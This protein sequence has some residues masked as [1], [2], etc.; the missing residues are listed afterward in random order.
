[1]PQEYDVIIVGAGTAGLTA[2]LYA[3]RHGLN[4]AIIEEF[5]TGN[6]VSNVDNIETFPGFP[7][8]IQGAVLANSMRTQAENYG[9]ELIIAKVTSIALDSPYIVVTTAESRYRAKALIITTGSHRKLLGIPEEHQ[10][11]NNGV[12]Q[13]AIF[14][15]STF[16]DKVVGVVGGG[17]SALDEAITL[18]K[19]SSQ[20]IIIHRGDKLDAQN[21]L[22]RTVY[23][24]PNIDVILN[25]KVESIWGSDS[26][27]GIQIRN[28]ITNLVTKVEISGLF[29]HI[30]LSPNSDLVRGVLKTD[31]AGHI[32]VN[33]NMGTQVPGIFAA[34]DVRQSSV[35]QL[36]SS[37]GDGATAAISCYRYIRSINWD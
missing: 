35:S 21:Y 2:G 8:G 23:Q 18:T 36:A 29:V 1:M 20:V 19:Y 15:G 4:V 32:P 7:D 34:G 12:S 16:I 27:S 26:L 11:A 3:S 17:D 13:C 28:L 10:F 37:A 30:G 25:T 9:S 6:Q 24:H 31:N 14:D 33:I 5:L 22:Q